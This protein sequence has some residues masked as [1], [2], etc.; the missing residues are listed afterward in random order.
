MMHSGGVPMALHVVLSLVKFHYG[1]QPQPKSSEGTERARARKRLSLA[2]LDVNSAITVQLDSLS[3]EFRQ[4]VSI[5]SVIG[6]YFNLC[7]LTEVINL[8]KKTRGVKRTTVSETRRLLEIEDRFGF[9]TSKSDAEENFSF[10]HYLVHR[11]V[12]SALLP[13]RREV[14]RRVLVHHL[15]N[16]FREETDDGVLLPAIIDHLTQL[17]GETQ[18]K[19]EYLFKGF[20]SAAKARKSADAFY[21][22]A[23]LDEINEGYCTDLP[24]TIATS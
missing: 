19:S 24:L 18:L 2:E 16:R 7:T 21:Y 8:L 17:E 20:I 1:E 12:F 10:S 11:G 13:Q 14:I 9:V 5:A 4:A 23:M 22:R 6:Q 3:A 15:I